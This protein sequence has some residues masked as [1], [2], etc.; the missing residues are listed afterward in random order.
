MNDKLNLLLG[1]FD[2]KR[3]ELEELK[4]NIEIH[5]EYVELGCK[6]TRTKFLALVAQGFTEAQ[7]LELCK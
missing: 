2:K 1:E 6:F 7:A 4:L 3:F 5:L